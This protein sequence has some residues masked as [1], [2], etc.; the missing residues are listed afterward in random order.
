ME[1]PKYNERELQDADNIWNNY[2]YIINGEVEVLKLPEGAKK[3]TVA[4]F[5][6]ANPVAGGEEGES[7]IKTITTCDMVGRNCR[8]KGR[9]HNAID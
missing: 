2:T 9:G 1:N 6:A 5:K 4:E 3:M 8:L 7:L